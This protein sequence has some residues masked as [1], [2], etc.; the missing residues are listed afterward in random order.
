MNAQRS[1][2]SLAVAQVQAQAHQ[3]DFTFGEMQAN[4]NMTQVNTPV[5]FDYNF[6]PSAIPGDQ[7][8]FD[9][10][11]GTMQAGGIA[12][13]E[14]QAFE[15]EDNTQHDNLFMGSSMLDDNDAMLAHNLGLFNSTHDDTG[16]FIGSV[17]ADGKFAGH[18]SVISR[19]TFSPLQFMTIM[20]SE[21]KV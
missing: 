5:G 8:P 15:A 9:S 6:Y 13:N 1:I 4:N 12:R 19:L 11:S 14:S 21:S 2:N 18:S 7:M 20:L 3:S 10:S 17:S 16:N